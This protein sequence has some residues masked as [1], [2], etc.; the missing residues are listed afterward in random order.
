MVGG[1]DYDHTGVLAM[2]GQVCGTF[3]GR[4]VTVPSIHK[5]PPSAIHGIWP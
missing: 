5:A 2:G 4:E 1:T 3:Y